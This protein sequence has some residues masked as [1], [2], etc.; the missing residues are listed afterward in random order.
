MIRHEC[1]MENVSVITVLYGKRECG[2]STLCSTPHRRALNT[3]RGPNTKKKILCVLM[4]CSSIFGQV[5]GHGT[6]NIKI[7]FSKSPLPWLPC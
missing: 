4:L 7:S 5:L 2:N 1:F 3:L 6:T